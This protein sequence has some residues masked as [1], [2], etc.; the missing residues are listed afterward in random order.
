MA[1]LFQ[2]FDLIADQGQFLGP[3]PAFELAFTL[4]RQRD[5]ER[6]FNVDQSSTWMIA[7]KLCALWSTVF[8]ETFCYV[9]GASD[10][11][12]AVRASENVDKGVP[13]YR[14]RRL[15]RWELRKII[16]LVRIRPASFKPINQLETGHVD[17]HS[18][19]EVLSRGF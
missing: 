12:C 19:K 11:D 7:S 13:A 4:E 6:S 5:R 8:S 15:S 16:S 17:V 10:V 3:A 9:A 18:E 2:K 14:R 1:Q